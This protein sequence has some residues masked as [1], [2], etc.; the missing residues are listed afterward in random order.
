MP[1]IIMALLITQAVLTEHTDKPMEQLKPPPAVRRSF[2]TAPTNKR[3][4]VAGQTIA[5]EPSLSYEEPPSPDHY[6][7]HSRTPS[8]KH[9]RTSFDS[10]CQHVPEEKVWLEF[11][12]EAENALRDSHLR[13]PST[14]WSQRALMSRS[15]E[16]DQDRQCPN[17]T[18]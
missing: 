7:R 11:L 12:H 16:S 17:T 8:D 3:Q 2:Q 18:F 15:F 10:D 5:E 1:G 13:F 4:S 14:T 6:A 9:S